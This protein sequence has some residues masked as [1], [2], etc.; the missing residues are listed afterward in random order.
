MKKALFIIALTLVLSGQTAFA[1]APGKTRA[2][3]QGTQ[4][5]QQSAQV[6]KAQEIRARVEKIKEAKAGDRAKLEAEL[7]TKVKAKALAEIDRIAAKYDRMIERVEKMTVI[8]DEK[9]ADVKEKITT[10][11][12]EILS[13]KEKVNAATTVT[14]VQSVMKELKTKVRKNSEVVKQIV[15]AIHASHLE[16]VVEKLTTILEKLESKGAN[17]TSVATVKTQ[18]TEATELIED[19][20]FKSAK[21]KI[22]EARKVMIEMAKEVD[23]DEVEENTEGGE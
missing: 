2:Q 16:G 6:E 22:L 20:E 9:K 21:E 3:Q 12:E 7:V 8:T 11:K 10:A 15:S 13:Y 14:E 18:L 17:T 5:V 4:A 19:G 1:V 23:S